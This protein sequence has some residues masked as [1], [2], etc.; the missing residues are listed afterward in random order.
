VYEGMNGEANLQYYGALYGSVDITEKER[1]AV[2][3]RSNT[4]ST[5]GGNN[6]NSIARLEYTGEHL[7]VNAGNVIEMNE[8][9]MDGYGG[10]I[11][12]NWKEKNSVN[13]FGVLKSR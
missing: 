1:M 7:S 13:V 6:K 10:K 12:Y 2:S 8:F 5:L 9:M 3:L 4:F 11:A